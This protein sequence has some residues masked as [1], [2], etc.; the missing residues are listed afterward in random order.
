MDR[1]KYIYS[2][3]FLSWKT[4]KRDLIVGDLIGGFGF[5]SGSEMSLHVLRP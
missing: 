3:C 5:E 1:W 2:P 4:G